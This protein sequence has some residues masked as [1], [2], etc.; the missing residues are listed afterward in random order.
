MGVICLNKRAHSWPFL[1]PAMSRI[2]G[3]CQDAFP[4]RTRIDARVGTHHETLHLQ[5]D[6]RVCNRL[7]VPA[8]FRG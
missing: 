3:D 2:R 5:R 4:S 7:K 8:E 6:A 1:A